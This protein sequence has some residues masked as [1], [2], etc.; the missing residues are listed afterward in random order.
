V[1]SLYSEKSDVYSFGVI[2]WEISTRK[3]PF[4]DMRKNE[5]IEKIL[6]GYTLPDPKEPMPPSWLKTMRECMNIN[7]E[8]RPLF[9]EILSKLLDLK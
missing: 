1:S 5:I 8:S 3:D 7:P 9:S 4:E 6:G 2:M